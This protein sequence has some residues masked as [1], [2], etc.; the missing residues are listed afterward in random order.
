MAEEHKPGEA[1]ERS[2]LYI[3]VHYIN[4]T[5]S[6]EVTCVYGTT[7]P[8]C[9]HCGDKVRFV[10]IYGAQ[11]TDSNEHFRTARSYTCEAEPAEMKMNCVPRPD[12][13]I[14]LNDFRKTMLAPETKQQMRNARRQLFAA[15]REA[16]EPV[17]VTMVQLIANPQ[18][19][20]GK[21]IR[22]IGFL[23]LQ[24]EGDVLY[25]HRE[26]YERSILGNG[27]WVDVTPEMRKQSDNLDLKYVLLEGVFSSSW[28]GHMGMWSGSMTNIRRAEPWLPAQ[29]HS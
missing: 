22:V 8:K 13:S 20:D 19:F 24:F 15:R 1:V 27:I 14:E 7:F 10:L 18:S 25:L 2:G 16:Q 26:D 23:Q 12:G 3:V 28:R 5:A 17:D 6:H 11:H 4:H 29:I 21:L 9:D